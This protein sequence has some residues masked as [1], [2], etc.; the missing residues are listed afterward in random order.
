MKNW[1]AAFPE[2]LPPR[3]TSYYVRVCDGDEGLVVELYSETVKVV[4]DFGITVATRIF[5]ETTVEADI[6]GNGIDQAITDEKAQ[7][8]VYELK[9]ANFK[10]EVQQL[11]G[12]LWEIVEDPRHYAIYTNN[13]IVEVISRG[14]P[15]I[16]VGQITSSKAIDS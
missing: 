10:R 11:M 1:K 2:M 6:H 9:D 5:E 4:L 16:E 12:D 15:E 8:V 13:Y 14:E 7:H 3:T